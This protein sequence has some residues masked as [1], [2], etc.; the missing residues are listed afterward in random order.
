MVWEVLYVGG[1]YAIVARAN[2]RVAVSSEQSVEDIYQ[3]DSFRSRNKESKKQSGGQ[4]HRPSV[5]VSENHNGW[6]PR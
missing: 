6:K 2:G 4:R 1:T 3:S 5:V